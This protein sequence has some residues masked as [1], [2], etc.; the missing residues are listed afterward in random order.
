VAGP[1]GGTP[2]RCSNAL[3]IFVGTQTPRVTGAI[4]NTISIG[5]R[6]TLYG[7]VD[8]KRGHRLL[9]SNDANRC[10]FGVC[11]ARH[12]PE[13]YSVEY[14]A[15]IAPSSITATVLDP[16]IQD[17]SFVKL[18]EVSASYRI[19]EQWVSRAGAST[20]TLTVAGR[21]LATWTDYPGIDPEITE[22]GSSTNFTQ[23]EFN[24]QP[25]VRHLTARINFTF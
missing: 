23:A 12:F 24:T 14:L 22:T 7:L 1:A 2:V 8:F 4:S 9:N 21:N 16:F 20:A 15:A 3:P 19:P 10:T 25:P 6:L 17:A 11:E 18:R 13:R 5:Q